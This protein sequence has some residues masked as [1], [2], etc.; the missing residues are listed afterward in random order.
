VHEDQVRDC[1][2]DRQ[3]FLDATQFADDGAHRHELPQA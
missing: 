2:R 1:E 3:S